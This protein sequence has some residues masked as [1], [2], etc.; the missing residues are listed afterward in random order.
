[1]KYFSIIVISKLII[2]VL[3][4]SVGGE[5]VPPS[6][7][8]IFAGTDNKIEIYWFYPGLYESRYGNIKNPP[9]NFAALTTEP[10]NYSVMTHFKFNPPVMILSAGTFIAGA[11]FLPGQPGDQFTPV[12]LSLSHL[13]EEDC[14]S[15]IW[16]QKVSLDSSSCGSEMVVAED[17]DIISPSFD[18][19]MG[20]EWTT[21]TACAPFIGLNND[22]PGLEQYIHY[23]S[24]ESCEITECQS[25]FMSEIN[26]LNWT[27]PRES[28]SSENIYPD[29]LYFEVLLAEDTSGFLDQPEPLSTTGPESLYSRIEIEQNGFICIMAGDGVAGEYSPPVYFDTSMIPRIAV[30]PPV[31]NMPFDKSAS[32]SFDFEVSNFG[33]EIVAIDLEYD[34]LLVSLPVD[35][36]EIE[37]GDWKQVNFQLQPGQMEDSLLNSSIIM[38]V[39][40]NKYPILYHL[41]FVE[42]DPTGIGD[43]DANNPNVFSVSHPYPDP[44]N[45]EVGFRLELPYRAAVSF[46]VYN[47]LGQ[48]IY[49]DRLY[50]P[51]SSHYTWPGI[52]NDRRPVPSGVYLFRFSTADK[53]ITRR[54]VMLK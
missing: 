38:T 46:E 19:W 30:N 50:P 12:T 18:I 17:I 41:I 51:G 36:L 49:T 45:S 7:P 24:N 9:D 34:S 16:H 21:D 5:I 40:G 48:C 28:D 8:V 31:F 20:I 14:F 29:S 10:G 27:R 54:G 3:F 52:D 47:I 43:K 15:E 13:S 53:Q 35:S 1:M 44:F 42:S 11:D 25:D 33:S 6:S 32:N 2:L 23:R 37:P 39:S 22:T 26:L 4:L